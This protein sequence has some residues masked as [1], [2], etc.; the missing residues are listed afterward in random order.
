MISRIGGIRIKV[1]ILQ[2]ISNMSNRLT[3]LKVKIPK[4]A[5]PSKLNS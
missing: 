3:N 2:H 1:V 5:L 4:V